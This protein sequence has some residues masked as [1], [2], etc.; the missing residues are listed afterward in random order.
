[1]LFSMSKRRI[2]TLFE[3]IIELQHFPLSQSSSPIRTHSIWK[4]PATY[5]RHNGYSKDDVDVKG[6]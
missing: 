2:C 3:E 4:L 1:M 6:R 5:V